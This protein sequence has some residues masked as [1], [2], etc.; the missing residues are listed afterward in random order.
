[1]AFYKYK[2]NNCDHVY[3]DVTVLCNSETKEPCPVCEESEN[4]VFEYV[5]PKDGQQT[6]EEKGCSHDVV[7]EH[8]KR[9]C[10]GCSHNK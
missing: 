10:E 1:M 7:G 5:E 4:V 2:C 3:Y 6:A 9:G 8:G